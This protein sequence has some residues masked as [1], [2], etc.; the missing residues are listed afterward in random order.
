MFRARAD[1]RAVETSPH[2]LHIISTHP[3]VIRLESAAPRRRCRRAVCTLGLHAL[4]VKPRSARHD[5]ASRRKRD[6]RS[7]I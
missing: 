7:T 2:Y 5:D 6:P 3:L 4:A 1:T